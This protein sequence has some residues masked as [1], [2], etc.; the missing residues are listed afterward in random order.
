VYKPQ[1]D[2]YV[3]WKNLEGWV[4]FVDNEY[5]TIEIGVRNKSEESYKDSSLHRKLH[6]LILCHRCYWKE[7]D[8]ISNRRNDEDTYKSQ[9]G[10][11]LD[12]Q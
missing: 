10:R 1:I 4:Y 6:C 8:Y 3:K 5:F 2:D 11:Y 7:V 9:E 12:I